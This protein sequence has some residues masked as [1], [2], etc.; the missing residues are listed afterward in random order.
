ME[1]NKCKR[2][3]RAGRYR[4]YGA[5]GTRGEEKEE[6]PRGEEGS[7]VSSFSP[8][9]REGEE[10]R[11]REAGNA[12]TKDNNC[13]AGGMANV[14]FCAVGQCYRRRARSARA[15]KLCPVLHEDRGRSSTRSHSFRPR[16]L[17]NCHLPR[18]SRDVPPPETGT[19]CP[20][21]GR[22]APACFRERIYISR[23][24]LNFYTA[25]RGHGGP[26]TKTSALLFCQL[27][28]TKSRRRERP[29]GAGRQT[30]RKRERERK[31]RRVSSCESVCGF[32]ASTTEEWDEKKGK[33][34]RRG[35]GRGCRRSFGTEVAAAIIVFKRI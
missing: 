4:E 25:R 28:G 2:R 8:P 15:T 21:P 5:G 35:A 16:A 11:G 6:G 19:R 12:A 24:R 10:K 23:N 14:N 20:T 18:A 22:E 1:T 34:R 29:A 13:P 17:P 7:S 26:K 27:S 31:G 9:G 32:I 33:R 30:V 3:R